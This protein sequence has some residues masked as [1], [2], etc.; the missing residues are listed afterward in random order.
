M[1]ESLKFTEIKL[2]ADIQWLEKRFDWSSGDLDYKGFNLTQGAQTSADTWY[3]WKYTW[4][5]GNPVII[6]GPLIGS[7]DN[8]AGLNWL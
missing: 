1:S 3:I 2:A 7:W 4:S 6:D 8:R 5:N